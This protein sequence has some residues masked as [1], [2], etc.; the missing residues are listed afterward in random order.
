MS[1]APITRRLSAALTLGLAAIFIGSAARPAAADPTIV[2]YTITNNDPL[3]RVATDLSLTFD[4][5]VLLDAA[6]D[7]IARSMAWNSDGSNPASVTDKAGQVINFSGGKPG[8]VQFGKSDTGVVELKPGATKVTG[9]FSYPVGANTNDTPKVTVFV[10]MKDDGVVQIT[11]ND[12]QTLFFSNVLAASDLPNSDFNGV[13]PD[14]LIGSNLDATTPLTDLTSLSP[15]Q[16]YEHDFGVVND[17]DYTSVMFSVDYVTPTDTSP[18]LGFAG[19]SEL[20]EPGAVGVLGVGAMLLMRR[21]GG[22]AESANR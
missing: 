10:G 4:N 7:P 8:T 9:S 13:D 14:T 20:P 5:P 2:V 22:R 1:R 11:N 21:K 12:M 19:N 15:G 16:T 6:K 3:K 17:A 18:V